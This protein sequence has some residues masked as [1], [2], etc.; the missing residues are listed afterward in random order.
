[1]AKSGAEIALLQTSEIEPPW[2][3]GL[4]LVQHPFPRLHIA[5]TALDAQVAHIEGF[6][7]LTS[8]L[9]Y[10]KKF[11]SRH[12]LPIRLQ[13]D[14]RAG[15]ETWA[16][17]VKQFFELAIQC[18][19]LPS[20]QSSKY[21]NATD[22]FSG[23]VWELK[24]AQ[25]KGL[26]K[27][28]PKS[29]KESVSKFRNLIKKLKEDINPFDPALEP[30]TFKLVEAAIGIQRRADR[31]RKDHWIPFLKAWSAFIS[32]IDRNPLWRM[33]ERDENGK[34]TAQKGQGKYKPALSAKIDF[35]EPLQD[36]AYRF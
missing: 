4:D 3:K 5:D 7:A 36:K 18:H 21:A 30:H 13:G 10:K 35:L 32:N 17:V 26:F 6:W 23:V 2:D 33:V 12:K 29:K 16:D 27:I 28:G 19:A 25:F 31:W 8:H 24:N 20:E 1:M 11:D 9:V 22:W 14:F 34:F 15:L